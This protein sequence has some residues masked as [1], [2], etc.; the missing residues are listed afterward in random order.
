MEPGWIR[1][2]M[3]TIEGISEK[4]REF[5]GVGLQDDFRTFRVQ[6]PGPEF[7]EFLVA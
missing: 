6:R 4:A 1:E 3:D 2:R 5:S 7:F